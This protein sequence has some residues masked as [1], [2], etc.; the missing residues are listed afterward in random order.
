[1]RKAREDIYAQAQ[2]APDEVLLAQPLALYDEW[3]AGSPYAYN[4]PSPTKA[5][6]TA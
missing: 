1:M 3:S 6:F 4:S 5:S 2:N